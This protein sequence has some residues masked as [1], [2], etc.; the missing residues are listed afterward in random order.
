MGER[1]IEDLLVAL[2]ALGAVAVSELGNGC[3][4]VV[5]EANGL[6]GGRITLPGS[7]SSQF[8]SALLMAAPLARENVTIIVDGALV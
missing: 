2:R 1:P 4:P 7:T 8:L 6:K 5:V 3:P